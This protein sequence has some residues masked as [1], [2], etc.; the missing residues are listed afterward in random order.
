LDATVADR[1]LRRLIWL[2]ARIVVFDTL[3]GASNANIV[4]TAVPPGHVSVRMS[5]QAGVASAVS[6]GDAFLV[7]RK[8]ARDLPMV[9]RRAPIYPMRVVRHRRHHQE[10][11][12][13]SECG[14]VARFHLL[15][16]I[17]ENSNWRIAITETPRLAQFDCRQLVG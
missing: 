4:E 12:G 10:P 3:P 13:Q 1:L 16:L 15:V 6:C 2:E 5:N 8:S 7:A 9:E 11:A 14:Y 17:V